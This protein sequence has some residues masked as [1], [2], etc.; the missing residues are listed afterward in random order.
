L[1]CSFNFLNRLVSCFLV[2]VLAAWMA[3]Y[4]LNSSLSIFFCNSRAW[5]WYS[6]L[7][8]FFNRW[9]FSFFFL[10]NF[11]SIFRIRIRVCNLLSFFFQYVLCIAVK[12]SI[13]RFI[14]EIFISFR[15]SIQSFKS[16]YY[17]SRKFWLI[18]M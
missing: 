1:F 2:F 13:F 10:L 15:S 8:I 9:Y 5:C 14:S 3:F 17:I 11:A 4:I 7:N 16:W 12:F 18:N 6:C